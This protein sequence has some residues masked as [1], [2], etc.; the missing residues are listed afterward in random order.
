MQVLA[1]GVETE[2]QREYL[3]LYKCDLI[4][5]DLV[6]EPVSADSLHTISGLRLC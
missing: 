1:E 4:Q 5:G 2:S 3:M 6:S